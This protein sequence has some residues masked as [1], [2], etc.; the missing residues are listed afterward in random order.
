M[1]EDKGIFIKNIYYMLSYAFQ[2]LRQSLYAEVAVEEFQN[3]HDLFA[4]ILARGIT[5]QIK[6]GLHREYI[7]RSED[8][9][10]MKGKLNIGGSIRN[11]VNRRHALYCEFDDL[12]E[13]NQFNKILKTTALH[14]IRQKDVKEVHREELSKALFYFD[15][16]D[17]IEISTIKWDKLVYRR[18]NQSYRML[19]NICYFVLE[20]LLLTT[21]EGHYKMAKFI[22]EKEMSWLFEKFILEY[23]RHHFPELCPGA[24]QVKWDL[25]DG[26]KDY[27]PKM[28]TDVMLKKGS[29]T[30]IID[31]KYYSKIMQVQKR[32]NSKSI[33]SENLY[34]IYTYVKNADSQHDGSVSGIILYAK[35]NNDDLPDCNYCIGGNYIGIRTLNLSG[36]FEE[37]GIKLNEITHLLSLGKYTNEI[38]EA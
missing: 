18:S 16:V 19:I 37:I 12:S 23:Y 30:L 2:T 27:L 7:S 10:V 38:N 35:T 32:F 28:Q 36:S 3:V 1:T 25:A 5:Q 8:L 17:I 15:E 29:K 33:P 20:S 6:R 11:R 26:I 24:S 34:Q 21:E 9:T 31:A 4:A 14:L 13:N 22:D